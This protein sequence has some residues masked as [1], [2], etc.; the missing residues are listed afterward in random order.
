MKNARN[1]PP[2]PAASTITGTRVVRLSVIGQWLP[3]GLGT[4]YRNT[5]GTRLLFRPSAEN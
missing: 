1:R 2:L 5:F 4:L 3:H